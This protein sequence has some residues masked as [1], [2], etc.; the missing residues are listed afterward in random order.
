MP[1][2]FL[3][4]ARPDLRPLP[5]AQDVRGL[6]ELHFSPERPFYR[7]WWTYPN[8]VA[9]DIKRSQ[10]ANARI[11]VTAIPYA[12]NEFDLVI[13]NHVLGYVPEDAKGMRECFRVMKPGYSQCRST[14]IASRRSSR[15]P[16]C[17]SRKWSGF[18]AGTV[19][20]SM[21]AI[22]Q[23]SFRRRVSQS[24]ASLQQQTRSRLTGSRSSDRG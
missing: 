12:D 16:T 13:C 22:F 21:G 6:R 14:A 24:S 5:S 23:Q 2:L 11:D 1:Q 10:V 4:G 3:E 8:Y 19:A 20:V 7:Q 9:C 15:H 18:A 17:P